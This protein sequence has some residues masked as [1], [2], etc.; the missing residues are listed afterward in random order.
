M[1]DPIPTST[2]A[3]FDLA[4]QAALKT[5]RDAN[6]PDPSQAELTAIGREAEGRD[7]FGFDA[8]KDAKGNF[9][10]QG[11]GSKG[12]ETTNHFTSIRRYAGEAAYQKAI[13]EIWK[14]D[15]KHAEKIGLPAPERISA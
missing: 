12:H 5:A 2:S 15:P 3:V 9:I 14:R 11:I 13:R 4:V 7:V 1:S 8:A 10:P 6:R